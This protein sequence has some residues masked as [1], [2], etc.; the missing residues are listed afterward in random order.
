[1]AAETDISIPGGGDGKMGNSLG[2]TFHLAAMLSRFIDRRCEIDL[3][4][5]QG[6]NGSVLQCDF[7]RKGK[8]LSRKENGFFH[9]V[10]G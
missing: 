10:S 3:G 6:S 5:H 8:G 1:M 2:H 4:D 7:F 9:T